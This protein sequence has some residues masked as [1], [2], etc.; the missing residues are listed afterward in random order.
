MIIIPVWDF[1]SGFKCFRREVLEKIDLGKIHS[2]GHSFQIELTT[3]TYRL[4]FRMK[5]IPITFYGRESGKSKIS[6]KIKWEAFWMVIRLRSPLL[7]IIKHLKFFFKD[8]SEF[9]KG[10][11][12][13]D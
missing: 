7:K 5:E 9:T 3:Y 8:Y 1:T 13:K 10:D 4:G 6:R 11:R 12:Q 2:D